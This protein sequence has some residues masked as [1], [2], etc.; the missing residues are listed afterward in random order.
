MEGG[1]HLTQTTVAP[2]SLSLLHRQ[3]MT[4]ESYTLLC[5]EDPLILTP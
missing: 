2:L 3:V 1:C 5:G 4:K